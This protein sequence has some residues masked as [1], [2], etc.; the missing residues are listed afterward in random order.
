M[1]KGQM[2]LSK[3]MGLMKLYHEMS[4]RYGAL[5]RYVDGKKMGFN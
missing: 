5:Q 1:A 3:M 2:S 4:H